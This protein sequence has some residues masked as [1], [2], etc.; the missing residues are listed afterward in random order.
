M[1]KFDGHVHTRF[2]DGTIFY[3]GVDDLRSLHRRHSFDAFAVT[4][5]NTTRGV[6]FARRACGL[7]GIPFIPGV[8]ISTKEGHVV[9]Y[10]VEKWVAPAYSKTL[11]EVLDELEWLNA[12]IVPAHPLD[13][14]MG[15]GRALFDP[16]V[17]SRVH[18]YE[19]WNGASP[20]PNMKLLRAVHETPDPLRRLA[21]FSGSDCHS[22][23]LFFRFHVELE[24]DSTRL[25][26]M[27]EAMR[28]PRNVCPVAPSL[29]WHLA[30]W[31][32]DY[33]PAELGRRSIKVA[34]RGKAGGVPR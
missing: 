19:L 28:D 22:H 16:R 33:P 20:R 11:H 31:I 13:R 32:G 12:V 10:G 3:N 18:G 8:E 14:R 25:D 5:H 30:R 6:G 4:D 17:A 34:E 23:V 24:C 15:I 26:D 2:S 27:L 1:I 29:P 21:R 9:A 7:L